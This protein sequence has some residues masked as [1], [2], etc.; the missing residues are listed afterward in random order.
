MGHKIMKKRLFYAFSATVLGSVCLIGVAHKYVKSLFCNS[1]RDKKI[2]FVVRYIG[3]KLDLS[4]EQK[5]EVVTLLK[6]TH[7]TI[8]A[9]KDQHIKLKDE[10]KTDFISSDFDAIK[11]SSKFKEQLLNN[12]HFAETVNGIHRILTVDQRIKLVALMDKR[13]NHRHHFYH[14]G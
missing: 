14:K 12:N 11:L 8:D 4:D 3:K 10:F 2:G 5:G 1:N 9:C 6:N 7:N 13:K